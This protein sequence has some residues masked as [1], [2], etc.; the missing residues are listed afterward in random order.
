MMMRNNKSFLRPTRTA[1]LILVAASL[2]SGARVY[3][4][5]GD[6]SASGTGAASQTK[7][8]T[9]KE[10][11]NAK[12]CAEIFARDKTAAPDY[13]IGRYDPTGG[14]PG[15]WQTF[16]SAADLATAANNAIFEDQA[17]VWENNGNIVHARITLPTESW[18][19]VADYCFRPDGT[20][21]EI[22]SDVENFAV[23]EIDHHEWDFDNRARIRDIREQFLDLD[24][25]KPRKP[26]RDLTEVDTTIYFKAADLPFRALVQKDPTQP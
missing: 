13:S 23:N 11:V 17:W 2:V 1:L 9:E 14:T 16:K 26:E 4:Q 3:A 18:T 7:A 5:T 21:A 12:S 19:T 10:A 8:S 6:A 25:H 15:P 20:T 24:T 22:V